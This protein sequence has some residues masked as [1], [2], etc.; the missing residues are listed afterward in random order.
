MKAKQNKQKQVK[1]RTKT[2]VQRQRQ[3]P[4]MGPVSTI[5]TAPVAFG[6]TITGSK[7]MVKQT[8][9]GVMIAGRDFM[10]TAIQTLATITDWSLVGGTPL[11]PAAFTDSTLRQYM[12]LYQKFRWR[13]C[14]VHYI[15]SS[16][17]SSNGDVVFYYGK[18]RDSVFL[19][20]TSSQFLPFV[21]SDP[22]TIM[23][24]QWS[25]HSAA[26]TVVSDWK[27]TDYGMHSGLN[28]Y[29]AGE[30]FLLSKTSSTESPGYVIFDYVI[31]F[32]QMQVSPRLLT[33]PITRCQW[34][35]HGALIPTN[36]GGT[37]TI[38]FSLSGN[39]VAG[40]VT[41]T[42]SFENGDI[43]K[44]IVD[45]A[46]SSALL[47]TMQIFV[48]GVVRPLALQNGTTIY[49]VFCNTSGG[50]PQMRLFTSVEECYSG[51]TNGA[52]AYAA[53]FTSSTTTLILWL[54]FVGSLATININPNF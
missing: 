22:D 36:P 38:D 14:N 15:T 52:L 20:P 26:L 2:K 40:S 7:S 54:S 44:V 53:P 50:V 45:K 28:D 10:F 1:R 31:E 8:P 51:G 33:L 4:L 12:Q 35:N 11:S 39:N 25:N 46:N 16:P 3:Q 30:V 41:G 9:E 21:I 24:P 42:A 17:T 5:T 34:T 32:A 6:N 29:A 49:G 18:N 37:P 27:S 19:N 47:P 43:Y 23:G 48:G 13:A